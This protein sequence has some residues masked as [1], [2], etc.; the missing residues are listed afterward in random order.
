MELQMTRKVYRAD[1]CGSLVR[2]QKLRT[3]R[4]D[5]RR[6]R[7]AAK[8]LAPVEDEALLA[9]LKLQQEAGLKIFSDGEF[10]R[11]F[12]LSAVSDEFFEGMENQGIDYARH[13]Y[14]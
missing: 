14:L 8:E 11:D 7:I 2:P 3:A 10:R 1:H 6:G 13:P 12:W 4:L 9:A 5:F